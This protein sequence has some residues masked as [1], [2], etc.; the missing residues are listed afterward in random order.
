MPPLTL[1]FVIDLYLSLKI[2]ILKSVVSVS[3]TFL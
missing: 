3:G 1:S 2:N